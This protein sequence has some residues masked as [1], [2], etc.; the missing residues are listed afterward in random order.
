MDFATR[1]AY[2]HAI[3]DLSRGSRR[4]ETEIA[5]SAV[6][7]ASQAPRQRPS[8]FR[9]TAEA[10]R[11]R[12]PG[13]YLISHGRRAF[14]REIGFHVRWRRR[15]LRLYVRAPCRAI[16]ARS[17]CSRRSSW[18]C[19]WFARGNWAHPPGTLVLLGVLAA[20]P[21]SDLAI[22]LVNRG[23]TD[24]VRPAPAA[25]T[26]IAARRSRASANHRRGSHAA[27]LHED[28]KEQ[29]ERLEIHYLANSD[30][31]LRFA[32]LSDWADAATENLPNDED[33]L[34]AAAEGIANLE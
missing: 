33:L 18:L 8:R 19:H 10:D 26:G 32:L 31:D 4:S 24:L 9:A 7:R 13:Y 20:I 2:R 21:A 17:P 34:A 29:V 16:W 22:A 23:V 27:D 3:E 5:R 15:L 12:D 30:G 1:D 14:E 6:K 25:A 28:V 11:R